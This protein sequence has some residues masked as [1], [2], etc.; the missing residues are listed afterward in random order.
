MDI[1]EKYFDE[2]TKKL[3]EYNKNIHYKKIFKLIIYDFIHNKSENI[4]IF[5]ECL[6]G[7]NY[8]N[9]DI[10]KFL[11]NKIPDDLK[12]K[13]NN[14]YSLNKYILYTYVLIFLVSNNELSEKEIVYR[15]ISR[16]PNLKNNIEYI[17]LYLKIINNTINRY[18]LNQKD[19]FE[20]F[21]NF[22]LEIKKILNKISSN[23]EQIQKEINNV[24][25]LNKIND[26][27]E[28]DNISSFEIPVSNH[29]T[30]LSDYFILLNIK[31][32]DI[33]HKF[34]LD[35]NNEN[36]IKI[37]KSIKEN[38]NSEKDT[39]KIFLD[40]YYLREYLIR[41]D[42]DLHLLYTE[43]NL[44]FIKELQK[45]YEITTKR[46]WS[47]SLKKE[48]AENF[49]KKDVCCLL[50]IN[51]PK[52]AKALFIYGLDEYEILIS[53]YSKF[54][55]K[56]YDKKNNLLELDYISNNFK[57][58]NWD[59]FYLVLKTI[60]DN[61]FNKKNTFDYKLI[62]KIKKDLNNKIKINLD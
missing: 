54:T 52:G 5:I 10:T 59:L 7:K 14:D 28:I 31:G 8:I 37:I 19:N 25:Y 56:S 2:I 34:L 36:I 55:C 24:K 26:D 58:D 43:R 51:L 13:I 53:P 61:E 47:S 38:I 16:L 18:K 9:N 44:D 46:F 33:Y 32:E 45:N 3:E 30:P 29:D 6:N 11:I 1:T 17:N 49:V 4:N 50:K 15:G 20:L 41:L 62:D 48:I 60:E 12:N 21:K 27:E 42:Y 57:L 40:L 23:D 35:D 22:D 39:K